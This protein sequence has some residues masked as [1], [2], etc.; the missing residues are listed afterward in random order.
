LR[1]DRFEAQFSL[2]TS[3]EIARVL[4]PKTKKAF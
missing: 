4:R 1:P 2:Q 3:L